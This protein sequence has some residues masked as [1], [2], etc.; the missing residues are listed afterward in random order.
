[1]VALDQVKVPPR[2]QQVLNRPVQGCSNKAIAGQLIISPRMVKQHWRT[3][4]LPG[5]MREDGKQVKL[6]IATFGKKA[7]QS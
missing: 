2:D 4:F 5:G 7:A 6:A 1:M 3:L